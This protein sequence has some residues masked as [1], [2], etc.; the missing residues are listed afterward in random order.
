MKKILNILARVWRV[1][2]VPM[3]CLMVVAAMLISLVT[4]TALCMKDAMDGRIYTA[5]TLPSPVVDNYDC[6]LVLGAGLKAD[7]TPSDMLTDRV[8]TACSL[9]DPARPIPIIMSGDHTDSYNE[10]AAM[11]KLA[12]SLGV[13]SSDVFLDHEGYSTYE[14]VWRVKEVFGAKRVLI[15]TQEYHL[16]RALFIARELGLEADGIPADLRA[17]RGATY[18]HLREYLARYKDMFQAGREHKVTETFTPVDLNGDG[19]Q[20]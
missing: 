3:L 6:I 18:R 9:Y 7:G 12:T 2:R 19:D 10:V 15:V 8:K 5:D 20:T 16:T 17:Y 1:V 11:K 13:D 4:L 14:S